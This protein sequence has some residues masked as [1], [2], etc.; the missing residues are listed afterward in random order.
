MQVFNASDAKNKFGMLMDAA[1]MSPVVIRK[2]GRDVAV[3]M[4]FEA[5]QELAEHGTL[6]AQL[7]EMDNSAATSITGPD[8]AKLHIRTAKRWTKV[9]RALHSADSPDRVTTEARKK[10][11]KAAKIISGQIKSRI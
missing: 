9:F 11:K 2:N 10:A 8:I 4:A 7:T 5:Y 3:V 1:R 6:P